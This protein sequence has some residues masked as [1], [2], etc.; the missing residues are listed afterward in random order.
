MWWCVMAWYEIKWDD[1]TWDERPPQWGGSAPRCKVHGTE[2]K[3]R[4]NFYDTSTVP[5]NDPRAM[6]NCSLHSTKLSRFILTAWSAR[7]FIEFNTLLQCRE[8]QEE[9][10]YANAMLLIK[11]IS[12]A[13]HINQYFYKCTRRW[14]EDAV[15]SRAPS[16]GPHKS[17]SSAWI[18]YS[19]LTHPH[20]TGY[21][22][23]AMPR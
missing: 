15:V 9:I 5:K 10:C 20:L 23:Q 14:L 18:L 11:V 12:I 19:F 2:L 21:K 16:T 4:C 6:L 1:M 8:K 3:R 22:H 17:P 7:I 13:V